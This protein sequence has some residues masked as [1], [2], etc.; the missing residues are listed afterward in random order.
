[1]SLTWGVLGLFALPSAAFGYQ[2]PGAPVGVSSPFSGALVVAGVQRLDG[3]QQVQAQAEALRSSPQAVTAR[4]ASQTAYEGLSGAGAAK[5]A[6]EAFPDVIQAPA[7]GAPR[8][9]SGQRITGYLS[10]RSA[11]LDLGA[12][13]RGVLESMAPIAVEA[14]SG[15]RVPINLG[16]V[17]TG[18]A[19]APRTPAV[20]VRIPK[21]LGEGARL[22]GVGVSLTPVDAHGSALGGAAG[23]IDGAT[24]FYANVQSDSDVV[25]KP[26]TLGFEESTILRSAGS[27]DRLLFRV[28]LP[29]GGSLVSAGGA[30]GSVDVVDEGAVI[31]VV[32]AP[33]ARDAEG[34]SVPVSMAVSG[35]T[36]ALSVADRPGAYR[37]PIVVDPVVAENGPGNG[38][39]LFNRTWGFYNAENPTAFVAGIYKLE[40][41]IGK[42]EYG[43][44]DVVS[45]SVGTGQHAFFYYPTQGESKIYAL[46]AVTQ[47]AGFA[48]SHFENR[49][50][51]EN[52]HS[53]VTEAQQAWIENYSA[54][55]TICTEPGCVAGTVT[56]A[57]DKSEAFYLQDEREAG[58]FAG[59]TSK[60]TSA[61]VDIAQEAAPSV[62]FATGKWVRPHYEYALTSVNATDPGLGINAIEWRAPGISGWTPTAYNPNLGCNGVQ[63]DECYAA[64]CAG[65]PLTATVEGLP[66]GEDGVE[67]T[68]KDPVGLSATAKGTVKIDNLPPYNIAVSGLPPWNEIGFGHYKFKVSATDGTGST[69]S[70][71]VA[72]IAV[73]IDGKEVGTPHGS[74]ALGPCTATGEWT[75]NGEEYAAGK[76]SIV[77]TATDAAG[78]SAKEEATFTIHS[79]ESKAVGPGSV[80]LASG[81]YA[82]S[83]TDVAIGSPGAGLSVERGYQSRR[84][85]AGVEG[86]LGPQWQGLSFGGNESLSKLSTG[87]VVLTASS[88]QQSL[89]VKE[90]TSFL[91]P[92]GDSNLTVKEQNASTFTLSDQRG[93]VTTFTVPSGGSGT[94]FTPSAREASGSPGSIKYTFQ[95][96]GGVTEPTQALA[97]VPAGV[98]CTTLVKGCRALSFAYAS[99]TTA[100]GEGPAEWGEYKGR[101][102]KI[103]FTAYNPASKEML[104]T[105]VAQYAYDKQGRLRAEWD[106]RISPALKRTYGYDAEGHVSAVTAPGQQPWLLHYGTIES[107]P[108]PG[109]LLSVVRPSA[110]T[111]LG[112][113]LPPAGSEAPKLSTTSPVLG[114]EL[115]VSTGAWSHGPLSYGYQWQHCNSSGVECALIAGATNPGYTPRYSDEGHTLVALVT[116]MNAGGSSTAATAASAVIP[117]QLFAPTYS[118]SF[119]SGGSSGGKFRTP[120]YIAL[121][122]HPGPRLYVTDTVNDRVEEFDTTGTYLGSFGSAG[123]GETQ[124]EEPTG[125]AASKGGYV[126][127]VDSG[128]RRVQ[129][130]TE[131]HLHYR[132]AASEGTGALV[133]VGIGGEAS[134][135]E[136]VANR[137]EN[138]MESF[139]S[140]F[141]FSYLGHFGSLGS[142][143]G[144]FSAPAGVAWSPSNSEWYVTDAT[145]NRVQYF[146]AAHE[147]LGKF[148]EAGVG[149]GQFKEPRGI[150]VDAL[151]NVWVVDTGNDRVQEFSATGSYMTQFGKKQAKQPK[152]EKEK[153]TQK[154]KEERE[155]ERELDAGP[156]QFAVPLGIAFDSANDVYVVDSADNRVEQWVPG[157]RPADLPLP[158]A[159]PPTPGSSAVWTLA[160]RVP[161][162]GGTAPYALGSNEIAAW[163]QKDAAVEASAIFPPDE[164]MGWPAQNYKRA[165]VYYRDSKDRTVNTAAPGAAIAT[166]EYNATNDVV[167]SL[168]AD[169]RAAALKEGSKSSETSLLLDTE[170][171]YNSEGVELQS[172][173]A[174]QHSVKLSSGTEVKARDYKQY[175][176][177]EGAPAE[178]GPYRLLTKQTDG[179]QYSGKEQDIRS[180]TTSYSG[181]ENLG[182]KLRKPTS[183]T[184]DPSALKLTHTIKY[185]AATG[186]TIETNTP[187]ASGHDATVP[188]TYSLAFGSEGTTEGKFKEPIAVAVDPSGNIWVTDSA[189]NRVQEFNAERKYIRQFGKEGVKEAEFKGMRGIAANAAGDVYVTD[190]G[191]DRVQE[192]TPEGKWLRTFGKEGVN[193]GEFK[194]P[195]GIAVD[196]S[197]N[198]WI[199]D[200]GN[201]RIQE[202]N[203][204][205]EYLKAFGSKG[206]ENGKFQTPTDITISGGNLY[207][208]DNVDN[209]VEEFS[210]AGSYLAQFG[211]TGTGNGQFTNVT[212]I[213]TDPVNGDLY[214]DDHGNSRI[215]EF[216]T[217]GAYLAQFGSIG[218]GNGQFTS[219]KGIALNA[220][221][222]AYV[223]D[224]GD[225]RIE[226]WRATVTGNEA[227]H[228]TKTI[229]Y[230]TA[231]N[232]EYP[233]CG[234]HAEWANLPCETKPVAQP[235]TSGLPE[236]S[237]TK[238]T[239]NTWDEPET[240]TETVGSTTRT[241]TA[242]YDA[243]GRQKTSAVSSTVGN[244]LPTVTNEYN[245]KTGTLQ[246]QSTTTEGKTKAITAKYNTLAQTE[247]YTDADENTATYSYDIDGRIEKANDGK[248]TQTYSYDETTGEPT[249][250]VDSAAGTFTA[251]YD[252]EGNMLTEGYPNGM[253]ANYTYNPVGAATA[254][255]YKKTTHCTEKCT[256]FSDTV[257][258]SIHGQWL[259]Q[260]STLSHQA[261]TYD[262]TGRL[263]QTQNT[264][265][266][267]SCTT[268]LYAYDENTNRT[269]LTTREPNAKGE[270]A[271]TGGTSESH[272][273][274]TAD[275]LTDT[276][277]AYSTFGNITTLPASD[278]G[279]SE[280][281]SSYYT[282]NQLASQTQSGQ[283]IGYNL[284]PSGRTRETLYTGKKASD[285][286][287][288]YAG[289]GSAPA[290]TVN[291]TAEWTRNI[292]GID[293]SL[294]AVQ[295][296]GETPVLQ[297]TNLHG[298]IIATAYLSETATTL[299]STADTSEFGL[300]TTSLPPKYS[301]L[302]ANE[303]PTE[304]PSGIIDMGARS[305]I[306]QLGRFLQPDPIPGGSANAYS[307]T[308]GDPVNTSD[309]SGEYTFRGPSAALIRGTAQIATEA[310]AEQAAEN[311]AARAEAELK[312]QE[313]E[314][315]ASESGPQYEEEEGEEGE[316]YEEEEEEGEEYEY[317]SYKHG[318]KGG[319]EEAHIEPALLVQPLGEAANA[320][321]SEIG[322]PEHGAHYL[323]VSGNGCGDVGYCRGHWIKK[324][325]RHHRHGEPIGG[326][327]W[328]PF[329]GFCVLVG[330][331]N[332]MTGYA[333]GAYGVIRV[334]TTRH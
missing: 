218:T 191:N 30:S 123:T 23:V 269:S 70:S 178:G 87:S 173:L 331:T 228:N 202:F 25:L 242:T 54:S 92:A 213:A 198:V 172:T 100:T 115:T 280:L 327:P 12:G 234:E 185:E 98:S 261:Y 85:T 16:V 214:V 312:A 313:A 106:P 229:Y 102:T 60:M 126:M 130:Y 251:S 158:A 187:A 186:N 39:V 177:D 17:E 96:V 138:R 35:S 298:D 118:S 266:G 111:A 252:P 56:S 159:T 13:K 314:E 43:V 288:H 95:T 216:S 232:S 291:M 151:G 160:Y 222:N 101:V 55:A 29:A 179:A 59:G 134:T 26:T 89:F 241:K 99:S 219:P 233:G 231:A 300:P 152:E 2:S 110:A 148:G 190:Y 279:G 207:V 38:E 189:N 254:L 64:S 326:S 37:F 247:S 122:E 260:T 28:G 301:W 131:G 163:A 281:T 199:V 105:A 9:P 290:W 282:D 51:I 235:G 200:T 240:T 80:E 91:A 237:I 10:D 58:Q 238:Y 209:R 164:P 205:G 273:Y 225:N 116:A 248:G 309:P 49:I 5:L 274:D 249:H 295:N 149:S 195:T 285:V 144:Q 230:S 8:L 255:E 83:A 239:Y 303:I 236:L 119:G 32:S 294:A 31:A 196:S 206:A 287:S 315:A 304:L 171:T 154:E 264:P 153:E 112:E 328:E 297:L 65:N 128:N 257:M 15:Q 11:R 19:F 63:C 133:G 125:I 243:A 253:N 72:S 270:C 168:S 183:I 192:F 176:Y 220:A 67:A 78:N 265:T 210:T 108:S 36:L 262:A 109:R 244:A 321:P 325:T 203:E 86:P 167:R 307:Y 155:K 188:P 97:P 223:V 46:T 175:S 146:N 250:L 150:T 217:A 66:E 45:S 197:G 103:S 333:C 68:V 156:G 114:K 204:K 24:L 267:K 42:P 289:P 180:T 308:F 320:A 22:A 137:G 93:D 165:T 271:T 212:R 121:G 284:D 79:S 27:P 161:V 47:Y 143:N 299:A 69:A 129:W 141:F 50:G 278:A 84:L 53:A 6:G 90:G 62:S 157:K 286:V 136:V 162:F 120:S 193:N 322:Q 310:V 117:E 1:M 317:A 107:D 71:G 323:K 135:K 73:S 258:P 277:L 330:W 259:E 283:T 4:E 194:E 246:K 94:L 33:S 319:Q 88:G 211:S 140:N 113:G 104:S 329:D 147:Y 20:E 334:R 44:E 184:A 306:P 245:E 208:V 275:R 82:L 276:G 14:G 318:A 166:T 256:W 139:E 268:R 169:N 3:N 332:P 181:Q 81:A 227:T 201:N 224:S 48:G 77:M 75:V 324:S 292:Q 7:G 74:C 61:T 170:S 174:P 316:E 293:G 272:T 127:V 226:E 311:A 124:F 305:Y 145:N 41:G 182:W 302:G 221:G 40:G 142:G 34:R 18:G 21:R 57:N 132:N 76:H 215:E 263:T 296:N 52:V